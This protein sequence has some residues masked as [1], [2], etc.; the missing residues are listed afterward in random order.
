MASLIMAS[1]FF[2]PGAYCILHLFLSCQIALHPKGAAWASVTETRTCL[3]SSLSHDKRLSGPWS[4]SRY[5]AASQLCNLYTTLY[6]ASG[7][8]LPRMPLVPITCATAMH[9]SGVGVYFP[10]SYCLVTVGRT[11]LTSSTTCLENR[12]QNNLGC[13]IDLESITNFTLLN[14]ASFTL[15]WHAVTDQS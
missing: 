7:Q 8:N 9:Y 14:K 10:G 3:L 6:T 4:T 11:A 12:A 2:F 15:S 1:A 5:T 13:E